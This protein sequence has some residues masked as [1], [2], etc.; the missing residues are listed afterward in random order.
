MK[1]MR[2]KFDL[3]KHTFTDDSD[4]IKEKHRFKHA[5]AVFDG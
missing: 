1:D 3:N 4:E 2:L 5:H